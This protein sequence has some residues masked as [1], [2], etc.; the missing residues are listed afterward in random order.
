MPTLYINSKKVDLPDNFKVSFTKQISDFNEPIAVYNTYSTSITLDGTPTNV[1]IFS[2]FH[3]P[4]A[5]VGY[6][7]KY[8]E[9]EITYN[10]NRK[11]DFLLLDDN[12]QVFQR[13]YVRFDE[14]VTQGGKIQYK[15][16]LFGEL[17]NVMY[18][19]MYKD[20]G[21]TKNL[22]DLKYYPFDYPVNTVNGVPNQVDTWDDVRW[23]AKYIKKVW[24]ECYT[25]DETSKRY[26]LLEPKNKY[27]MPVVT[28]R[29]PLAN[30]DA[31]KVTVSYVGMPD[32]PADSY[33]SEVARLMPPVVIDTEQQT[34]SVIVSGKC[35]FEYERNLDFDEVGATCA[36]TIAPG[37]YLKAIIDACCNPDNNGGYTINLSDGIKQD[38]YYNNSFVLMKNFTY[39][40][41]ETYNQIELRQRY[42]TLEDMQSVSTTLTGHDS[43]YYPATYVRCMYPS[44]YTTWNFGFY[45]TK[46][47][48]NN[49]YRAPI[50]LNR[51]YS[52]GYNYGGVLVKVTV[53]DKDYNEY[54]HKWY[55]VTSNT[56]SGY[57]DEDKPNFT[58]LMKKGP[59]GRYKYKEF[60]TFDT[61]LRTRFTGGEEVEYIPFDSF[62]TNV[63]I[64]GT[65]QKYILSSN[66]DINLPWSSDIP[67]YTSLCYTMSSQYVGVRVIETESQGG[68]T[69]TASLMTSQYIYG[70]IGTT[71]VPC[72]QT[73][74]QN[75]RLYTE[76]DYMT[77]VILNTKDGI[78]INKKW[79]TII[80][81]KRFF[82]GSDTPADY[83]L[84]YMKLMGWHLLVDYTKEKTMTMVTME[85]FYH[86]NVYEDIENDIIPVVIDDEVD[87]SQPVTIKPYV[88]DKGIKIHP[89]SVDDVY[90]PATEGEVEVLP[91][92][93][94]ITKETTNVFDSVKSLKYT[95]Y[96][97]EYNNAM[98]TKYYTTTN[99]GNTRYWPMTLLPG[100]Y[101]QY[102]YQDDGNG[103]IKSVEYERNGIYSN[104]FYLSNAK[105]KNIQ[106][107]SGRNKAGDDVDTMNV[108]VIF[109]NFSN[110]YYIPWRSI[111]LYDAE[112]SICNGSN[113]CNLLALWS[114]DNGY[115]KKIIH[116]VA[117]C[118]SIRGFHYS[119]DIETLTRRINLGTQTYWDY[120][121]NFNFQP[122]T[123]TLYV[124]FKIQ[125][126]TNIDDIF[127]KIYQ[128]KNNLYI[129]TKIENIVLGDDSPTK[130]TMVKVPC[131]N[132][133]NF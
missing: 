21:T 24:D 32:I 9:D 113:A 72:Q 63:Q 77:N 3:L 87:Y 27:I 49:I 86:N 34:V 59:A 128:W 100:K 2:C 110:D 114:Q 124:Q 120:S 10:P 54:K 23:D 83:L 122:S 78:L 43:P 99:P 56:I 55:F 17:G 75:Y 4:E 51:R 95:T 115:G 105:I 129:I 69:Y 97:S 90:P 84:S 125:N 16:T 70:N 76:P 67:G 7:D 60:A 12:G 66:V 57:I 61:T 73:T 88:S 119:F 117:N 74:L 123:V 58:E 112:D 79:N 41:V 5:S 50:G 89:K 13:G 107:I 92:R 96:F 102:L 98:S 94:T 85:E 130:I 11:V 126:Q 53:S 45:M 104:V 133:L 82:E 22:A 64:V 39:D 8:K 121:G 118:P 25:Y 103:G 132:F 15:I 6:A 81:K 101:K 33:Y 46:D 111:S 42:I 131:K 127:R 71:V 44:F 80:T 30:F 26:T 36:Q 93:A 37:Y 38:G 68:T 109:Q 48:Y 28:K 14:A 62:V 19:L 20:D 1:D 18:N 40:D 29:G 106:G 108:M 52:N 91:E 116:N 31:N 35:Q 65:N 47:E